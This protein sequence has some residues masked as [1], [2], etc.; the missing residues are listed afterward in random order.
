MPINKIVFNYPDPNFLDPELPNGVLSPSSFTRYRR[1]PRQYEYAYVLGIV[2]PPGIAMVRGRA[3]HLGAEVVHK[4]TIE[5]K[6]LLP[7]EAARQAVSEQFD[8]EKEE[9]QDWEDT[10]PGSVKDRAINS[11]N[12]YYVQ[13]VPLIKPQAVEKTFAKRFGSVPVRGIIDLI[14]SVPGEYTIGD[15]PKLPPPAV[16]VV[17]DLKTTEKTW[18]DQRLRNEVQLTFY[19]IVEDTPYVRIDLLLDQKKS[20]KYHPLRTLRDSTDKK[21]LIEDLEECAANIKNG[22]FPRCDPTVSTWFCTPK[23]CGYYARCR[24]PK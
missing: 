22:R 11:F 21:V 24:G 14:D 4:H 7:I 23:F 15:D 1:C 2:S 20:C 9:V 6:S 18:S 17:S 19:S 13:A 5:H 3:V 12:I 16:E 8:K 10:N